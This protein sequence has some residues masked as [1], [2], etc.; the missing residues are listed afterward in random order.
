MKI[1]NRHERMIAAPP[2]RI[3]AL[4][5][6]LALSGPRRSRRCPGGRGTGATTPA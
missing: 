3:A 1:L 5:A 6:D 4:V 2:E